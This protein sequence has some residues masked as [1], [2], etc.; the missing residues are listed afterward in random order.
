MHTGNYTFAY[1]VLHTFVLTSTRRFTSASK[2]ATFCMLLA[3][4]RKFSSCR[5]AWCSVVS[6]SSLSCVARSSAFFISRALARF[7]LFARSVLFRVDEFTDTTSTQ[8]HYNARTN[9]T[10]I[11]MSVLSDSV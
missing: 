10:L 9:N 5:T 2:S 6:S 8:Y 1:T 7:W 11:K 3:V 4:R